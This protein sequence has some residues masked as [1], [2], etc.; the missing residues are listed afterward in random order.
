MES[1][2]L[3][4]LQVYIYAQVGGPACLHGLGA[5]LAWLHDGWAC[6]RGQLA[7]VL[8][9]SLGHVYVCA[10]V[11]VCVCACMC[12]CVTPHVRSSREMLAPPPL[13]PPLPPSPSR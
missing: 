3:T 9:F 4:L 8:K 12:V 6:A 1:L 10:C 2:P 5:S 13:P 7:C 11:R